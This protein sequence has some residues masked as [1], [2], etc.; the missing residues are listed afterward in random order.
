MSLGYNPVGEAIDFFEKRGS[1]QEESHLEKVVNSLV[2]GDSLNEA[3]SKHEP[4]NPNDPTQ[5]Y[6]YCE[7]C[8]MF[9]D[10]WKYDHNIEDAG[11]AGHHWRYVTE[12][13]LAELLEECRQEGCLDEGEE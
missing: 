6:I 1:E 7:D 3:L 5:D 11:H 12:E 10:Y 2:E 8:K 4:R 9:V 13:E